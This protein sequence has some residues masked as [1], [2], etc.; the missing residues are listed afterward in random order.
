MRTCLHNQRWLITDDTLLLFYLIFYIYLIVRVSDFMHLLCV[1]PHPPP[2]PADKVTPVGPPA[3]PSAARAQRRDPQSSR[4]PLLVL[5]YLY[6]D[7]H[8]RSY[9]LASPRSHLSI[10]CRE[11]DCKLFF[12]LLCKMIQ[13]HT[14]IQL[15]FSCWCVYISMHILWHTG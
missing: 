7:T 12:L 3:C 14:H 1:S 11:R 10:R 15:V 2:S 4:Y 9:K 5:L 6:T 8:I 13:S